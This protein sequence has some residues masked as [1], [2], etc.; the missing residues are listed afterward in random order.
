MHEH[1]PPNDYIPLAALAAALADCAGLTVPYSS[2]WRHVANGLIRS[3]R[4]GRTVVV[5]RRDLPE[6][7]S[8]LRLQRASRMSAA[9]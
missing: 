8:T 2:L 6:I 9:A 3:E 5:R 4:I 1:L 7:A